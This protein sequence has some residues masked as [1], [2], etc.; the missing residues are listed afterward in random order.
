VSSLVTSRLEAAWAAVIIHWWSSVLK[1]IGKA[2]S[3]V[4]TLI[5][6]KAHL[7]LF[8][9]FVSR[10]PREM[11]LRDRGAEHNWHIFKDDFHRA[12]ELSVPRCEKSGKEG[13]RLAW[14]SGDLL[15]KLKTKRELH[16]EWKQGQ[17]SWEEYKDAARLCRDGV[18]KSKVRLELNLARDTKNNTGF[19]RQVN[20]KRKVKERVPPRMNK[21]DNLE[22]TGEEKFEVLNKFLSQSSLSTSLLA[23][24]QLMESKMGRRGA[25]SLPTLSEDQVHDHLRNLNTHKSMGP[26]KMHPRVLKELADAIARQLSMIFERSWQSKSL[27]TG[28]REILCPFLKKVGR[29][30]LG[31]TDLSASPLCLGRSWNRYF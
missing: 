3:I 10:T 17:V 29:R 24:P 23:P 30:N 14:L 22:S 21:N 8:K 20:Q 26:D 7:Q 25:K 27:V 4:R 2:S 11:A 15:V 6:R 5:F 31:T 18:R 1:V 16:R 12:Q 9:E 13:K 28:G 19:Y